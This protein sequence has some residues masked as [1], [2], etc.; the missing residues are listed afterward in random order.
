MILRAQDGVRGKVIDLD[1]GQLMRRLVWVDL[2]TGHFEAY[3]SNPDGSVKQD[4]S[5]GKPTIRGIGRFRFEP[6]P[7]RKDP[8][9]GAPNCARCN[10]RLTLPGDDLCV[11]CRAAQEVS[12]QARTDGKTRNTMP[13]RMEAIIP[14]LD[15]HCIHY[16]CDR[17]ATWLVSDEAPA[18]YEPGTFQGK[19][20]W[21]ERG[22]TV[23]RRFYCE[24]HK[25]PPR[26]LD[27]RGEVIQHLEEV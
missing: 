10:S 1:T 2:D 25:Q 23:G 24:W 5:G 21:Y 16:G 26:L 7:P 4:A 14:V 6:A 19:K 12:K 22:V 17:V 15:Q 20:C 18:S 8:L 13:V 11:T 27:P 9:A 3:Q